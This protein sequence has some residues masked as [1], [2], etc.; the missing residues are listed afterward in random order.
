M[1]LAPLANAPW[2]VQL[3]VATVVPAFFIGTWLLAFSRKGAPHHRALGYVYLALMAITSFTALFVH[4]TNPEGVF[5]FS[6][7]HI[8]VPLTLAG[9][10]E[11]LYAART[12][13]I[14]RHRY[15]MIGTYV[16]ALLI[17]GAF[18]F[19]PGRIMHAVVFD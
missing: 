14:R 10:A 2:A 1:N 9:I 4:R 19:L 13:Q 17:A 11:A 16:S 3:H 15:A 6:P 8:F 5:G 12:H 7:I 18:T